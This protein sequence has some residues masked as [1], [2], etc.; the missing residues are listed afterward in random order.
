MCASTQIHM[1]ILCFSHYEKFVHD[2]LKLLCY[3]IL[4]WKD[5][6]PELEMDPSTP[7]KF[8]NKTVITYL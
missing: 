8:V 4:T 6:I 3:C 1:S 7:R 2:A 5:D